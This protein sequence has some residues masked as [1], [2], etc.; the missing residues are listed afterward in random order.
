[1]VWVDFK[2]A[3]DMYL[4]MSMK[5]F[6]CANTISCLQLVGQSMAAIAEGSP[7]TPV[8]VK[9]RIGVDNFDSY[10]LLRTYMVL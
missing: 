5:N 6:G 8:T 4:L 2:H 10:D 7:G 9:C 3:S 1:M